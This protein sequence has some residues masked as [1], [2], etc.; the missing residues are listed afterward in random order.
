M[1][2]TIVTMPAD[3][4]VIII[5]R[6]FDAPRAL[7]FKMFTDPYHL[8]Q[9]W[10]PHGSTNPV[11]EIDPRP[12]GLWRQVMRFPNGSEYAH[13][14]VYIEIVE[15]ERI[16]YRDVPLGSEGVLDELPPPQMV[17]SI[18]FEEVAGKTKL[19]S[20]IRAT[21]LAARDRA[22]QMGFTETVSQSLDRLDAYLR[23]L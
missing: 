10:G 14:S 9:F 6:V 17:T 1:T 8:A 11:C 13:D 19:T 3:D 23:T 2:S 22:V 16:V 7:V 15:P 21:S 4:S 18:L 12:G 20:H 5:E